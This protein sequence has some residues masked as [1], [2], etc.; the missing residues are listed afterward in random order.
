MG[1]N[2]LEVIDRSSFN[3]MMET[4]VVGVVPEKMKGDTSENMNR[5]T[6]SHTLY[7]FIMIYCLFRKHNKA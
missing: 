6:F 4:K 2:Y 1:L 7:Q 5:K 3:G